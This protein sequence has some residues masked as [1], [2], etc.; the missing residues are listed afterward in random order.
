MALA[1]SA[2]QRTEAKSERGV[3]MAKAIVEPPPKPDVPRVLRV[4]P[5]KAPAP[6]LSFIEIALVDE[7]G[8]PVAGQSYELVLANGEVRRGSLDDQGAARIEGIPAGNCQVKFPDVDGREWQHAK[9][10]SAK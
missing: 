6:E 1:P 7:D 9:S 4:I 3:H 10:E 5:E 2:P 8:E